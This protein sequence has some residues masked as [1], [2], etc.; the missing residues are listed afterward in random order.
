MSYA[1]TALVA[2][3]R[4]ERYRKQLASHFGHGIEVREEPEE[5]VLVFGEDTTTTLRAIGDA[6]VMVVRA[7]TVEDLARIENVTGGHLVRFGEKDELVVEW[8]REGAQG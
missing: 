4:A 5:T 7:G 1:S 2:T 8:R 3:D 6:L